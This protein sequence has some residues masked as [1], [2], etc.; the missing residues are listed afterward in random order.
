MV[1]AWYTPALLLFS[2][3]LPPEMVVMLPFALFVL[4]LEARSEARNARMAGIELSLISRVVL[5]GLPAFGLCFFVDAAAARLGVTLG[6]VLGGPMWR[7][8]AAQIP[9]LAH[10]LLPPAPSPRLA[11]SWLPSSCASGCA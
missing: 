6:C 8:S 1:Q 2:P 3:Q 9:S 4:L 7:R 10:W 5:L 11:S